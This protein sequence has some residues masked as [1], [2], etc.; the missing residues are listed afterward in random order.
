MKRLYI[1]RT[2]DKKYILHNQEFEVLTVLLAGFNV[3]IKEYQSYSVTSYQRENAFASCRMLCWFTVWQ[4]I[5][6]LSPANVL[7]E[8]GS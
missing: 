7:K 5:A 6:L 1:N 2:G 8:I 3:K 4:G